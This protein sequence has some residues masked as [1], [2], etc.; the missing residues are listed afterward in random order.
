MHASTCACAQLRLKYSKSKP[1]VR[2]LRKDLLVAIVISFLVGFFVSP[3]TSMAREWLTGS[4]SGFSNWLAMFGT[5]WN[6]AVNLAIQG[7]Y[8]TSVR[9]IVLFF[10]LLPIIIVV[11]ACYLLIRWWRRGREQKY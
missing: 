11:V 2:C 10:A 9:I 8:G 1:S 3:L 7:F 5:D 4:V 6:L